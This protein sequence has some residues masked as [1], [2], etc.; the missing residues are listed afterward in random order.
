MVAY[1]ADLG[2]YMAAENDCLYAAELL[3][4][5][6]YL[7]YLLGVKPDR[8]LVEYYHVRIAEHCL[9]YADTLAVSL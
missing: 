4:Q 7:D 1:R 5:V 3:Y 2:E 9:R 6:A 8:R